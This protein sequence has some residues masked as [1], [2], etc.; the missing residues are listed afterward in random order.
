VHELLNDAAEWRLIARLFECPSAQWHRDVEALASEVGSA[1]LKTAAGLTGADATEGQY[2]SVFG[3]GG[4][5]PPRE[6]S[7]RETIELGSLMSELAGY[8][9]AFGYHP[10]ILEAP[11]HVAVEAGFMAYLRFKEAYA[12]ASGLSEEAITTALAADRF[13]TDHVAV[14]AAPLAAVLGDSG[15]EYLAQ[16][17]ALLAARAGD[18]PAR[19]RLPMVQDLVKAV[20]DE[21]SAFPCDT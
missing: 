21:G 11:D 17:S 19:T 20:D 18:P 9:E 16:A 4:P 1:A 6:V 13:R 3:P 8:Y 12:V 5:A 7:Y 2:H 15:I 10:V 14:C